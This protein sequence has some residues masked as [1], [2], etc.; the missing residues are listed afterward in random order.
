MP[1]KHSSLISLC[2]SSQKIGSYFEYRVSNGSYISKFPFYQIKN[3]FTFTIKP[4]WNQLQF[5]K[6][7]TLQL[8]IILLRQ[9]NHH[10]CSTNFHPNTIKNP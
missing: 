6:P 10:N 4:L 9:Q 8:Q 7:S 3:T 1:F 5:T 2:C